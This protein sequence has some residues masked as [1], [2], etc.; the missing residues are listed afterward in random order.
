MRPL[1]ETLCFKEASSQTRECFV[2]NMTARGSDVLTEM[3]K[4]AESSNRSALALFGVFLWGVLRWTSNEE[5]GETRTTGLFLCSH[6]IGC[7]ARW[8]AAE[9]RGTPKS[10]KGPG[11][12]S[13][14]F[15]WILGIPDVCA[16]GVS[17]QWRA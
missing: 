5:G 9:R 1:G 17:G 14:A 2:S 13:G 8:Q 3:R 4:G 12:I 10:G 15:P 7:G 11:S 6:G 16:P